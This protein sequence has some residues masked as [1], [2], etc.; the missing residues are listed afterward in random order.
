MLPPE[1]NSQ[2]CGLPYYSTTS[3]KP[4]HSSKKISRLSD[5]SVIQSQSYNEQNSNNEIFEKD[6]EIER[7]EKSALEEEL[8]DADES[9]PNHRLK[10]VQ[11]N[12]VNEYDSEFENTNQVSHIEENTTIH[13]Q[14]QRVPIQENNKS[15]KI[16]NKNDKSNQAKS[17]RERNS[18]V[19]RDQV[20]PVHSN[21]NSKRSQKQNSGPM[22][23]HLSSNSNF[24]LVEPQ[25]QT[26]SKP[27]KISKI[28][29][30][31][32]LNRTKPAS[33]TS[34]FITISN[35]SELLSQKKSSQQR[36]YTN[37]PVARA[38]EGSTE[39]EQD[40]DTLNQLEDETEMASENFVRNE[41]SNRAAQNELPRTNNLQEYD[42]NFFHHHQKSDRRQINRMDMNRN[43]GKKTRR[44]LERIEQIVEEESASQV[45]ESTEI[46][47]VVE[48]PKVVKNKSNHSK[49]ISCNK[50]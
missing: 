41:I 37:L 20:P 1:E 32:S 18:Q 23:V 44:E 6:S 2:H 30:S 13:R 43:S 11:I 7:I 50:K 35:D 3:N 19:K 22:E 34:N 12:F 33:S 8:E 29:S 42:K 14:V 5:A 47:S 26:I 39:S 48:K 16:S 49:N 4:S 31:T 40:L 45:S 15:L 28:S 27:K 17:G 38:F 10:P 36:K 25:L 9:L 46:E 24:S 21:K